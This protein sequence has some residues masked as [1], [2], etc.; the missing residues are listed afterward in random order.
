MEGWTRKVFF[1]VFEIFEKCDYATLYKMLIFRHLSYRYEKIS[2]IFGFCDKFPKRQS[3]LLSFSGKS[4]L[5][6][7]WG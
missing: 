1:D 6:N 5:A 7:N 4:F 3:Q 2:Y